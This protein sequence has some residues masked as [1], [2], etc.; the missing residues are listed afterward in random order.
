MAPVASWVRKCLTTRSVTELGCSA[1]AVEQ[2]RVSPKA[3][4][5]RGRLGRRAGA[6]QRPGRVT[7]G[8]LGGHPGG[9]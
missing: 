5:E 9:G 6:C 1:S 2:P 7:F 8:V 4:M 3:A